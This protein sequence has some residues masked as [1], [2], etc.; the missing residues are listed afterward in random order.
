MRHLWSLLSGLAVTAAV[1]GLF[2][3]SA[4]GLSAQLGVGRVVVAGLLLGIV[5]T[6]RIS[7]VGPIVGGLILLT[8]V[9]LLG[10]DL[11][12]FFD[13]FHSGYRVDLGSL[14]LSWAELGLSSAPMGL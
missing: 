14:H 8:P 11:P 2:S 4:M 6:L 9:V 3:I 12:L 13:L 5:A 7:P 10:I 1:I